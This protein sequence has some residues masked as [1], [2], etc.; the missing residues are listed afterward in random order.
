MRRGRP[1]LRSNWTRS[2][3]IA[4]SA[5]YIRLR[6]ISERAAPLKRSIASRQSE[7][8]RLRPESPR[9]AAVANSVAIAHDEYLELAKEADAIIRRYGPPHDMNL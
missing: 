9:I 6:E 1:P 8:G 3:L 7:L 2:E 5:A 4:R